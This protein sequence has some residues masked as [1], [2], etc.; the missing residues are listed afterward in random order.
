M[1]QQCKATP[2]QIIW[3]NIKTGAFIMTFT[4][5]D[6][7]YTYIIR[8][9]DNTLYTGIA[10][11]IP[12]RMAEHYYHKKQ[13][14]K[15]TKSRQ[16][17]EIMMVWKSGSWSAAAT[18]EHYIKSLT[19]TQKLAIIHS[20]DII[21]EQSETKLKGNLYEPLRSFNG[22]IIKTVVSD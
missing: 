3:E 1:W 4:P 7:S 15:Y 10:K 5:S 20:P 21:N 6:I 16:A 18:L 2:E 11:D 12:K 19:R 17:I 13:G 22:P 8:C 9:S 14:A